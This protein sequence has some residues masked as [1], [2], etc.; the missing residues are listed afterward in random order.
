MDFRQRLRQAIRVNQSTLCIGLDPDL[1]RLPPEL[2]KTAA[3][4]VAFNRAIIAATADL[5]CAYKPNS[6]FYEAL[7]ADGWLALKDT[8]SAV[9]AHIPVILD[10]K[11]GDIGSTARAYA[12][13]AF[14]ELKAHAL[15]LSPYLGSDALEPFLRYTD[16]G[17]FIL[18]QTSNPG[19]ADLQHLRLESGQ[20]LYQHIAQLAQSRWNEHGNCGLVVGATYPE[21][22]QDVRAIAPDVLLLVPGVGAQGG[23]LAA[24]VRAC[25][26]QGIISVS[27]A[28]IYADSASASWAAAARNVA[29]S[30]QQQIAG[31][32]AAPQ[33]QNVV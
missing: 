27:R 11:R 25:G 18:C 9:P 22:L 4:V 26:D 10:A 21:Q 14:D 7:G 23:D 19:A 32:L 29:Q 24:V 2:P 5:V 13:A 28:V 16:R 12:Q 30:L 15:T 1:D 6:A 31:H 3:G 8:I 17:C 20:R 33:A